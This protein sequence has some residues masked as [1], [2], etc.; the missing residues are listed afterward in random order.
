MIQSRNVSNPELNEQLER[1]D[2]YF[3]QPQEADKI[4]KGDTG[5]TFI[6]TVI[7]LPARN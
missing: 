3:S 6:L 7:N 4:G 2:K 5:Y 1:P